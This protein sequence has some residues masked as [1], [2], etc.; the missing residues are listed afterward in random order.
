MIARISTNF[1]CTEEELWKKILQPKSLQFVAF[2]ILSFKPLVDGDFDGKWVVGKTYKLKMHF[3]T[4]VPLG[5]HRINI[6]TIDKESN[7][8]ESHESGSLVPVWNHTIRFG[9]LDQN[10]LIYTDEIE[11]KAG[12]LT[13]AIWLFTQMFYRHRQR[14][15][16]ILLS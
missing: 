10:K 8:I 9:Q 2:P 4:F 14:R 12:W 1:Y 3:L 5:F 13:M 6:V 11:V 16:K 15:W 7:I